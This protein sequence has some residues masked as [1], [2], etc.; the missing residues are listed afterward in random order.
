MKKAYTLENE[1]NLQSLAFGYIQENERTMFIPIVISAG[2][3][4]KIYI[5][6][7]NMP[8]EVNG[9]LYKPKMIIEMKQLDAVWNITYKNNSEYE[10]YG[11]VSMVFKDRKDHMITFFYR[12]QDEKEIYAFLSDLKDMGV[13][14]IQKIKDKSRPDF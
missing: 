1:K 12:S 8:D 5:Y 4:K 3:D 11:H 2:K 7:D 10:D 13:D 9:M 6:Y 14:I